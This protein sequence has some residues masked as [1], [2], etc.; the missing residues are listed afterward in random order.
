MDLMFRVE[1]VVVYYAC[2]D[3]YHNSIIM[4]SNLLIELLLLAII[5]CLP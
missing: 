2:Y 4:A 5:K 3:H 1:F